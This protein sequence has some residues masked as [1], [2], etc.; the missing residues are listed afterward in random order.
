MTKT[1]LLKHFF[2]LF[3]LIAGSMS[4]WAENIATAT[5]N[6]KDGVYTSG[7]TTTGTGVNRT[8]CVIIGAGENITSPAFNLSGYS[9]VSITFT[10]RRYGSL[11]NSKATVDAS[12]GG[13]SVG[14]IDITKSSV[15]AVDGSIDFE[16]TTDMT[17]AVLV[18]T[19]TNATSAGSTH[20]AGI[21]SITI[22]GTK[23]GET[24]VYTV[25]YNANG[26]TS[27]TVPVD[28]NEYEANDEVTVLG[29]TGNLAKDHYTFNGWNTKAD[30]SGTGYVAG[31]TFAI[32]AN[33]TLYAKW[34]ANTNTVTLPAEDSYGTYTMSA[35][36]PVA[37]GTTVTLTYTPTD[38][39]ENYLATWS[40]NGTEI[41]G[42]SF[43][44]PD[45]A[46]TVTVELTSSKGYV[47]LPYEWEGGTKEQLMSVDGITASGLGQDYSASNNPYLIKFDNTG[48]YI[49]IKTDSQPGKVTIGVKMLG[50][51]STSKITVQ[52]SS[53][54][55]TFT[56][57][58]E[59]TISGAQNAV[60]TLETSSP[61]D[62]NDRYVKLVFT[63]GSNVGVGPITI[64]AANTT[65]PQI[66]AE[67]TVEL[68]YDA[69]S[70]EIPYTI[71]NPVAGTTLTAATTAGWISNVT[72]ASDKV[73]F[74][75]TANDGAE[76]TAT[77]TL[78]YGTLTKEVTVTQAANPN[79]PG[80]ED[81]P[82]TVEQARAAIDAGT[83]TQGVYATG[84]V[85]KIVTA[86]NSQYENIS[87]NISADGTTTA[88]QL[89]AYRCLGSDE[90]PAADV[91][92]GDEV[93]I[94]GN[95]TKYNTTYEFAQGCQIISLIH[96]ASTEPSV[97]VDPT[98]V[99]APADGEEGTIDVTYTNFTEVVAD[100][101]FC[102][103]DGEA[104][105][106]DWITAEINSDN[107]V[108]Y[109]IEAN[110]G[111]ARTAYMK[112]Y[113]LDDEENEVYSELITITQAAYAAPGNWVE[114][115]LADLTENDVFVIVGD[116]GD[117]Y[118]MSNDNGTTAAPSAVAVTVVENTLSGEVADNIQWNISI[119]DDGY[120]FYP[121]GD[122]ENWLYCTNTNNGVRVGTGD[123]KHFTLSNE[124][125]LTTTETEQQR[126]VGIYNS[127]DW[128]CYTS[129]NANIKDQSF[130]FYKKV[131]SN[132][133]T[134]SV[135]QYKWATFS[136]DKDL[137]FGPVSGSVKAYI[138]TGAQ[139]STILTEQVYNA[140]A[141]TGLLLYSET[142]GDYNIPITTEEVEGYSD[143]KLIAV[144]ED[145]FEVGVPTSGTNYVLTVQEGKVVFAYIGSTPAYLNK[146]QAYLNLTETS[147]PYLGF[148]GEGTTGIMSLTPA[149]SQG[150]GAC[151]DL[152]GR[153]VENP[154]KGVYI[155]NGKK[156]VI[157]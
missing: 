78:T 100:V 138:V 20:G 145:D 116:N 23:D 2:L 127:Q 85:S 142:A 148:D 155:V 10:G 73:T 109:M 118:A 69:T 108:E 94:Y 4:V 87:F 139:G 36:N 6:G 54:G 125:Y 113:A 61:F 32:S 1:R 70:G 110:E 154:T 17:S 86:Y 152:S 49:L 19:C 71:N 104:A 34:A 120:M 5:F 123:A 53:D 122:S 40:V 80:T 101:Y 21:G 39:Y 93:V 81:N 157:K 65:D 103:A 97:S 137:D 56:D 89:E 47:E 15:G 63:K 76:R 51:S 57:V 48:D 150:E 151:Y 58:E 156:V 114:T 25:T 60:L 82:Y 30:G 105:E 66:V 129:I 91:Q 124:N 52:G 128:R 74:T 126:F 141:G 68:A 88:D 144:T 33:T 79:G 37:Y 27:G 18:F 44:M 22:T 140:K 41:V 133:V 131:V 83:G 67:A 72:V 106:Y 43:T 92:V 59:L 146:G 31:G 55:E 11:S 119:T 134:A 112:V 130:K 8:D 121:N 24:I 64:A 117:T 149:L 9:E 84:I 29:N 46:V 7:W 45:E 135:S 75:A 136:S 153:R 111:E 14:T 3:A 95:L 16:P 132:T 143:N 35:T 42:N 147:A 50:G 26:A 115:S 107:D 102:D 96:H 62:A 13:T 38:G 90:Y 77:V 99:E 12:I 28:E 98:T